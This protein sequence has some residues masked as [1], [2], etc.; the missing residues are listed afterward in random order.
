MSIIIAGHSF[1]RVF[2]SIARGHVSALHFD[3]IY[4]SLPASLQKLSKL[5]WKKCGHDII[6]GDPNWQADML[7]TPFGTAQPASD[8][9]KHAFEG[10]S[11]GGLKMS[12]GG[13][14]L[15]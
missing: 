15:K 4:H 12:S 10:F 8:M 3:H 14:N 2:P 11:S 13:T 9:Q 7:K 6:T 1:M 5:T